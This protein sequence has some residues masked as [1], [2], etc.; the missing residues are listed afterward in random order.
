MHYSQQVNLIDEPPSS[1]SGGIGFIKSTVHYN[2]ALPDQHAAAEN[3]ADAHNDWPPGIHTHEHTQV[4][5]QAADCPKSELAKCRPQ[6][7]QDLHLIHMWP[8]ESSVQS[9]GAISVV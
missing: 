3:V 6:Q 8:Q 9:C 5:L 2:S 1:G 4:T 7:P